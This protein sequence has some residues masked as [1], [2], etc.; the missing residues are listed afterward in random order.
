MT[1]PTIYDVARSAGVAT[2]TV[3]R[4]FSNPQRVSAGTRER[5]LRVAHELGYEPNPHARAL[6][7]RR[8]QT[9][10]MVVS[11]I[12]NPHF[13]EIIRGAELR[14]KSSAF[15]LVLVNAEE[16]PRIE[17]EQISRLMRSVDGFLLAASRLPDESL[18]QLAASHSVVLLNRQAAGIPSVVLDQREGCRQLVAHLA[19]LG[20]SKLVC[21]SG[22]RNSWTS[23]NRWTAIR[24]AAEELG[25]TVTRM[26]PYTPTVSHGGAAADA[27][28]TTG[29]TAFIAHNDLLAI[30]VLRRLA[31]RGVRVPGDVSVSGF[32]DI[33]AADLC[34]PSLTTL[35]GVHADL[36][37]AAVELLLEA[38]GAPNRTGAAAQQLVLPS[39]LVL[40]NSTGA[41]TR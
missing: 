16:S 12:T 13:F 41:S 38:A 36:G 33:F 27:A 37:R 2:S 39:R 9:L 24:D 25:L 28:L 31:A 32:D 35:G 15:T 7:S 40:R 30:G 29:A 19:S 11:D 21:L 23:A 34:T 6:T 4:A 17:W 14:A 20:H 3:S 10:A 22:P 26:G 5:V 18:G 8:T 1:S